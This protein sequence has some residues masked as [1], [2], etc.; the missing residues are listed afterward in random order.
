MIIRTSTHYDGFSFRGLQI[1][2]VFENPVENLLG[3]LGEKPGLGLQFRL[4][5]LPFGIEIALIRV[6]EGVV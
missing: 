5:L 6:L 4:K 2:K 3:I 1:L